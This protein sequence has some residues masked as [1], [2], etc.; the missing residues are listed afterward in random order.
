MQRIDLRTMTEEQIVDTFQNYMVGLEWVGGQVRTD[1]DL[2]EKSLF[3]TYGNQ[4]LSRVTKWCGISFEV[5]ESWAHINFLRRNIFY[6]NT[7]FGRRI[8]QATENFLRDIDI[9]GIGLDA[10]SVERNQYWKSLGFEDVDV[11]KWR[12]NVVNMRKKLN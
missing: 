9:R 7:G 6:R 10:I 1:V 11:S 2:G 5:F 3:I 8:Y 12:G 4:G